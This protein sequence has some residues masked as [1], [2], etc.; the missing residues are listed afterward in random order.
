LLTIRPMRTAIGL[1]VF[2][3]GMLAGAGIAA[4]VMPPV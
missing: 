3:L 4:L 2:M 1:S